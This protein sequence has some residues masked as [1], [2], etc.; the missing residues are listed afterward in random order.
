MDGYDPEKVFSSIDQGGRYA[1]NNQPAI[2]HWNLACLAQAL[3]TQI[4][5][6]QEQAVEMAQQAVNEFPLIYD[7]EFQRGMCRKLGLAGSQAEDAALSADLFTLMQQQ[8]SDF[9]HTFSYLTKIAG[10]ADNLLDA[11]FSQWLGRWQS[12]RQLNPDNS[13]SLALMQTANPVYIPRNHLI[14]AA[15]ESATN[16]ED[17]TKFHALVDVLTDP[18]HER[19]GLSEFGAAPAA[20]QLVKH[21]FCGT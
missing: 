4:S 5:S 7:H 17:F 11:A 8:K 16:E 14:E 15:I 3:L 10:G 19:E 2:A 12:R 21:T 13:D 20:Y 9:T 1:Y 18:W 6:D